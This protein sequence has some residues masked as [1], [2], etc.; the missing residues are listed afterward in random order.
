MPW[1]P[2]STYEDIAQSYSSFIKEN[3]ATRVEV[4]FDSYDS[5]PSIRDHGH[6][7]RQN[8]HSP[9]VQVSKDRQCRLANKFFNNMVNN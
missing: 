4:V 7:R 2:G 5:S 1:K 6:E 8:L 3:F 9:K